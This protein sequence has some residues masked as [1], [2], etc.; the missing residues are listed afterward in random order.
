MTV[1][2]ASFRADWPEF[3]DAVSYPD[4]AINFWLMYGSKFQNI[5]VW[6]PPASATFAAGGV[7]FSVQP[8]AGQ[9]LTL[10]GSAV[11]FVAAGAIGLQVNIGGTLAV[12]VASL[13][14]LLTSSLDAQLVKFKYVQ[15]GNG[16]TI[17]AATAGAAGNSLTLATN[18]TGAALTGATLAGG[19][20]A[21]TSPPTTEYDMGMELLVAHYLV[22]NK[23]QV[24]AAAAGAPPGVAEGV[25]AS[26]SVG[27]ASVSFD[28]QLA[29]EPGAG[30]WNLTT[31]GQRYYRLADM[32]GSG[33]QM[34]FGAP[35]YGG[36]NG[37]AWG[38]PPGWPGWFYW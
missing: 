17:S 34:S 18:V 31:Y 30:H 28:T 7:A 25:I 29:G 20:D 27:P 19:A 4:A 21:A 11:T 23:K 32:M 1:T 6:G 22:L 2:P 24:D 38:G 33:P 14:S 15:A 35:Q 36:A 8:L 12:T 10:N 9:T 5:A 3:N 16:V 13:M 37:P 26:K